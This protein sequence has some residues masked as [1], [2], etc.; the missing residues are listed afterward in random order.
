[1]PNASRG[2][3]KEPNRLKFK[4]KKKGG[5]GQTGIYLIMF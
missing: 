3:K 2:A 4:K 5:G 1:M